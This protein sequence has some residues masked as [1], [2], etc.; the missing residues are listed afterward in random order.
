MKKDTPLEAPEKPPKRICA[1]GLSLY[2]KAA[3]AIFPYFT[4]TENAENARFPE[5]W[6]AE[7]FTN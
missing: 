4:I 3:G 5:L 6:K 1:G 7:A 2:G